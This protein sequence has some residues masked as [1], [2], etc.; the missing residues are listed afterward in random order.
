MIGNP[1]NSIDQREQLLFNFKECCF[2]YL[3]KGLEDQSFSLKLNYDFE[4]IKSLDQLFIK[5][6]QVN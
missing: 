3:L 2:C 1:Q 5:D 6:C 4:H